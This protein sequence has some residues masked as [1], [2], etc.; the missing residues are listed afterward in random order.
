MAF[1]LVLP[2]PGRAIGLGPRPITLGRGPGN[3]VVLLDDTVSWHHAQLWVE[4][5]GVWLRDL[6]SRNGTWCNDERVQGSV[7][8][9]I[10][11]RVRLG[12]TYEVVLQGD[13][14]LDGF[15]ARY[16]EAVQS[17]ARFL[18]RA[19]RFVIGHAEACDLR[20]EG[21]AERAAT[22]VFHDNGEVWLSDEVGERPVEVGAPFEIAGT[23]LRVVGDGAAPRATLDHHATV[24]PYVI[25]A[26]ANAPGGPQA[27][28]VDPGRGT[29]AWFDGNRGTLLVVLARKLM[30]DREDGLARSEQGWCS[31]A[32]AVT[33]VWGRDPKGSNRLAVLVHRL[34]SALEGKGFD[35]WFIE[36]RRGV[37][38]VQCDRVELR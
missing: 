2:A 12:A 29:E 6:A 3:D 38:R 9:A 30:R 28:V 5:H 35:P 18:V 34:R 21:G 20:L 1:E 10:G 13:G 32:E 26:V 36:K 15:D 11:D 33:G 8:L 4:G 17:G 23:V 31:T 27:T 25:R 37:I 24:S 7:R 16:V 14:A 22:L 19:E